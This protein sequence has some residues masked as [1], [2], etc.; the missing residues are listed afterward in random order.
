MDNPE[1]VKYH[2]DGEKKEH[3]MKKHP[4]IILLLA[5]IAAVIF[6]FTSC[7]PDPEEGSGGGGSGSGDQAQLEMPVEKETGKQHLIELGADDPSRGDV[8]GFRI[9]VSL[10]DGELTT[11]LEI[12]GS[13]AIYWLGLDETGNDGV[14]DTYRYF[15]DKDSKT[16]MYN[17][18]SWMEIPNGTLL[19]SVFS[20]AVDTLLYGAYDSAKQLNMKHVK[21][22]T[23]S[24][25]ECS[26]YT[27]SVTVGAQTQTI[28][29]WVDKTYGITMKMEYVGLESVQYTIDADIDGNITTGSGYPS[30]TPSQFP[31]QY[32][33][34]H[35]DLTS[36]T[37]YIKTGRSVSDFAG[38]WNFPSGLGGGTLTIT[39]G[40]TATLNQNSTDYSASLSIDGMTL[41][42]QITDANILANG[43]LAAP[44]TMQTFSLKD[45][46]FIHGDYEQDHSTLTFTKKN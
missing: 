26:L 34:I 11:A 33:G 15:L 18:S 28:K 29:F 5:L 14:I 9:I 3:D 40:G 43:F 36:G 44:E 25:R 24:G 7:K 35:T 12:G 39:S 22:E 41:Q 1:I 32:E 6:S 2:L 19:S 17:F 38:T 4:N 27:T 16:W 31:S 23:I 46:F 21:D 13:D 20:A 8:S 45:V 10:T 42:L 30:Y 37:S